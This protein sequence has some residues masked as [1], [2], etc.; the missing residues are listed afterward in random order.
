MA[1]FSRRLTL[2]LTAFKY[3]RKSYWNPSASSPVSSDGL[4]LVRL[5]TSAIVG[6]GS[7][8]LDVV[9]DDPSLIC[10]SLS[11]CILKHFE[12]DEEKSEGRW[13]VDVV[14]LRAV[15]TLCLHVCWFG[16]SS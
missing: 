14:K 12:D 15:A 11:W 5:M 1:S 4:V 7:L 16:L 13:T 8:K 9:E 6:G 2:L 3:A 10:V